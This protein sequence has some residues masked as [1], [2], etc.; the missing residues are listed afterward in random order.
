MGV[1]EVAM[2][3]PRRTIPGL[4][5]RYWSQV[6][7]LLAA[8]LISF[9]V[10]G[11]E[12]AQKVGWVLLAVVIGIRVVVWLAE[13][14]TAQQK[15]P[16]LSATAPPQSEQTSAIKASTVA[17]KLGLVAVGVAVLGG[18]V[19]VAGLFEDSFSEPG[20]WLIAGGVA[21]ALLAFLARVGLASRRRAGARSRG[22]NGRHRRARIGRGGTAWE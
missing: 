16:P 8:V 13:A 7:I 9:G 5:F 15:P 1:G 12:G 4:V 14:L 22:R 6:A 20:W 21:A 10:L 2:P 17:E 3:R 18:A 11:A 19:V